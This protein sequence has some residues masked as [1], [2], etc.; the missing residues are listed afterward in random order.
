MIS[1]IHI[2]D[3]VLA[4]TSAKDIFNFLNH[5]TTDQ[6]YQKKYASMSVCD[7]TITD[8]SKNKLMTTVTIRF[9]MWKLKESGKGTTFQWVCYRAKDHS[10]SNT[11][12]NELKDEPVVEL[13][14][15]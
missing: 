3:N 13:E 6:N 7:R 15:A 12:I 2:S 14:K 8:D 11:T 5:V 1:N 9:Q 4:A 10:C